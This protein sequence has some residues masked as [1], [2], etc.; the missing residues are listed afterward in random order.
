MCYDLLVFTLL[1]HYYHIFKIYLFIFLNRAAITNATK[2]INTVY[3]KIS[4]WVHRLQICF[5][6]FFCLE[7]QNWFI[8]N[9]KFIYI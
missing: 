5:Y 8:L 1:A 9:C 3:K 2:I 6:L 4:A 7:G